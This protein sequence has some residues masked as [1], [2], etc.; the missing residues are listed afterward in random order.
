MKQFSKISV[1]LMF[2]AFYAC[3]VE[4]PVLDDSHQI[5]VEEE[6]EKGTP[7]LIANKGIIDDFGGE[8]WS[9]WVGNDQ[10]AL[11]R[12]GDTLKVVAKSVGPKY[13]PFGKEFS[14]L[15]MSEAP[16]LK[17]RMRAEGANPPL[18]GISLK[19]VDA[20]DT[21]SDRPKAKVKIS[22]EYSDYYFNYEGKWK[23]TYP[24]SQKVDETMIREIMFFINPGGAEW[25]GTLYVDDI[26]VIRESDMPQV[27]VTAGGF[28]DDFSEEIYSWWSSSDKVEL[29]RINEVLNI[30]CVEAGPG[31]ETM[32]KGVDPI[33]MAR[34]Y[35]IIRVRARVEGTEGAHLRINLKDKNGIVNNEIPEI[36]KIEVTED[37]K[38]YFYEYKG[39]WKQSWPDAQDANP[40]SIQEVLM[41]INAGGVPGPF[42]GKILIQEIEVVTE[43]K[44][45]ELKAAGQ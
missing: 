6:P 43:S 24:N 38:D 14:L 2:L 40:E 42:S 23:Q 30:T 34:E 18:V 28:I 11:S 17:V 3:T 8:I 41:F 4:Q 15:D 5:A 27:E 39:K 25:T 44:M 36:H 26:R 16:V 32:G 35:N 21:N 12:K 33:N 7:A 20:Y 45:N 22:Q 1:V 9:W 13:T 29:E 37:F 19:D 10:L 31:F